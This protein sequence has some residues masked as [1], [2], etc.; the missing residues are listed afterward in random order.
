MTTVVRRS[1]P[2]DA[3][4]DA[5][6]DLTVPRVRPAIV[7]S[8]ADLYRRSD[9]NRRVM[10]LELLGWAIWRAESCV[11]R[12]EFE[13]F[14]QELRNV[15]SSVWGERPWSGATDPDAF[16]RHVVGMADAFTA[17]SPVYP[18]RQHQPLAR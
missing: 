4:P 1:Q 17:R 15:R 5:D 3:P 6:L 7:W 8:A 10:L 12:Q 14:E 18:S 11:S 13:A 9:T 16:R 2:K